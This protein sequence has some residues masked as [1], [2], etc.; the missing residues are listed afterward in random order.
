MNSGAANG[1]RAPV[2]AGLSPAVH[3]HADLD[4]RGTCWGPLGNGTRDPRDRPATDDL[5]ER[6]CHPHTGRDL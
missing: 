3:L 5:R 4:G 6:L 2:A 1:F